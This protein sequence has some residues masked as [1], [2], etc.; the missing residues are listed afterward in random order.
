MLELWSHR[1]RFAT[2]LVG[3]RLA[4]SNTRSTTIWQYRA[5]RGRTDVSTAQREP[6]QEQDCDC[7]T[8]KA[9]WR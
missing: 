1:A 3:G 9:A 7:L 6:M 8:G 5:S 2:S 4:T